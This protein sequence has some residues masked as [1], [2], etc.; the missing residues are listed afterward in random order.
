MARCENGIAVRFVA[1]PKLCVVGM[2]KHILKAYISCTTKVLKTLLGAII[3]SFIN[4]H[5]FYVEVTSESLPDPR[6]PYSFF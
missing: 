4:F 3:D 6:K 1:F 2:T 5:T